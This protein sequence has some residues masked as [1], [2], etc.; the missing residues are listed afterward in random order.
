M[1]GGVFKGKVW[2]NGLLTSGEFQ[3]SS[4][5]SSVGGYASSNASTFIKSFTSSY[6]GLWRDGFVTDTKDKI[7][8]DKEYF[9]KS[10]RSSEEVKFTTNISLKKAVIKNALWITGTFSHKNGEMN[11]C[12]WLDGTFDDGTFKN[13]SFN[14]YVERNLVGLPQTLGPELVYDSSFGFTG[15]SSGWIQ[16][17]D[18]S[19]SFVVVSNTAVYTS[20]FNGLTS[21]RLQNNKTY[22]ELGTY[23]IKLDIA[24]YSSVYSNIQ[25][26][27]YIGTASSI[28]S[29]NAY[30]SAYGPLTLGT[31]TIKY[32]TNGGSVSLH[33]AMGSTGSI[34][35]DNFSIKKIMS[36]FN[37][38]DTTCVWKNGRFDGGDF[39]ISKWEQGLFIGGTAYGMIWK[40]GTANYMNAYN[41]FWE[42]GLWRNGNWN[43]SPFEFKGTVEDDYVKQIIYRGMSWSGTSSCHI[44]NI[45]ENMGDPVFILSVTNTSVYR[46]DYIKNSNGVFILQL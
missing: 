40:S 34:K 27:I 8:K 31:N 36:T 15:T 4:V 18:P 1:Y 46:N 32:Q 26:G 42:D 21:L 25:L 16:I 13:S 23:E 3:G 14:P 6:Y 38:N 20:T 11:N 33:V 22:L 29:G 41:V 30:N 45:F 12:V 2:N 37:L 43:G 10:V 24:T 39:N 17:T 9:T 5:Y 35:L 44:W 19:S 28:T 7:V